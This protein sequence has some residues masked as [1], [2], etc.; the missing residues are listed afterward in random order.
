MTLRNEVNHITHSKSAAS[1][2]SIVSRG[3]HKNTLAFSPYPT[4]GLLKQAH[5]GFPKE[6]GAKKKK[7][8]SAFPAA[9]WDGRI[10]SLL[11]I[12]LPK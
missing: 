12:F 11:T 9:S 8:S 6:S 10:L 7:S 4:P 5:R 3:N 1:Y 2:K